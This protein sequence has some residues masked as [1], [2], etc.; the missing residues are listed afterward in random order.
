MFIHKTLK[1]MRKPAKVCTWEIFYA[2][3]ADYTTQTHSVFS[4][5]YIEVGHNTNEHSKMN[6][7]R[8]FKKILP[9]PKISKD[10][11]SQFF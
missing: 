4:D 7:I 8:R 5:S 10:G 2:E 11:A 6:Q 3:E 1:T 9:V